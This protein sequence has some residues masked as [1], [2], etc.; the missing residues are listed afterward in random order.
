LKVRARGPWREE[1]R[2]TGRIRIG[3]SI[4]LWLHLMG[5]GMSSLRRD[6]EGHTP[7]ACAP[8][9]Q[10]HAPTPFENPLKLNPSTVASPTNPPP[11]RAC[12]PRPS[13]LRLRQSSSTHHINISTVFATATTHPPC[14]TPPCSPS[15]T[16]WPSGLGERLRPAGLFPPCDSCT[17]AL[18]R[19]KD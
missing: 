7:E 5:R 14:S 15:S 1:A 17:P 3:Q 11:T 9:D 8:R 4:A 6:A 18:R 19:R 16:T 13:L 10:Q 12:K 2:Q